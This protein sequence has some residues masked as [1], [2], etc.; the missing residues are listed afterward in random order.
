MAHAIEAIVAKA[1]VGRVLPLLHPRLLVVPMAHV[2]VMLPVDY[3]IIDSITESRRAQ[4][5]RPIPA[6]T[7]GFRE[8]LQRLCIQGPL[9]PGAMLLL[10]GRLEPADRVRAESRSIR[11]EKRLESNGEIARAHPL[12]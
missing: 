12:R 4:H 3:R 10:P 7:W 5:D 2:F 1:E 11:A 9:A 8:T 6:L